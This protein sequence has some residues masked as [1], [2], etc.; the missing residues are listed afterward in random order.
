VESEI[1]KLFPACCYVLGHSM[2]GMGTW[3]AIYDRPDLFAA[4]IPTAG[5]L[6]LWKDPKKIADVLIWAFHGTV[7]MAI[8]VEFTRTVFEALER[9]GGNMK[10]TELKDVNHA[11]NMIA[12]NYKGDDPA[13]G[14][15]T[16]YAD[17]RCDKE[18]NVWDWLFKQKR[19]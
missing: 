11:L 14:W 9:C 6:A 18:G 15:I 1:G 8:P 3:N 5:G 16:R 13:K 19:N 7:D 4:A 17:A 12:F 10:Y 2:G